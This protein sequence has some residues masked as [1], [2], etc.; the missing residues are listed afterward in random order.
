MWQSGGMPYTFVAMPRP[1]HP[2]I[3][4]GL[5]FFLADLIAI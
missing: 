3:T 2:N 5:I 1:L 4:H